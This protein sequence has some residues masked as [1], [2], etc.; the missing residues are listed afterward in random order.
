[1]TSLRSL[2]AINMDLVLKI[3]PYV[4]IAI[5]VLC[6]IVGM[7]KGFR[8]VK[9]S[10]LLWLLAGGGFA[11]IYHFFGE[12]NLL[13]GIIKGSLTSF[14]DIIW[15]F[16]LVVACIG[17][18]LA[19]AAICV[20]IFRFIPEDGAPSKRNAKRGKENPVAE[21]ARLERDR[22]KPAPYFQEAY[23]NAP[24]EKKVGFCG[25]IFGGFLCLLNVLSIVGIIGVFVLVLLLNS[26][27]GSTL[28]PMLSNGLVQKGIDFVS[29]YIFDV[30]TVG[31]IMAVAYKGFNTGLIG[32]TRLLF[33]R[34][35]ML[36]ALIAGFALPFLSFFAN[37]AFVQ[38][39]V[40][41]IIGILPA[42]GMV[43]DVLA[44]L[45]LGAVLAIVGMILMALLNMILRKLTYSVDDTDA[46]RI[47]D[48]VVA[49]I[50]Y[51]VLGL[52]A[53]VAL[54]LVVFLLDHFGVLAI[55]ETL[56]T[57]P[58]FAKECYLVAKS[59]FNLVASKLPFA[60]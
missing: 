16:L 52:V 25:R 11:A 4:G 36:V 54:W 5:L 53:S 32:T 44:R 22:L 28:A 18:A 17:A 46:I 59:L 12:K 3:V 2:L 19:L 40:A 47:I 6:F 20:Y 48:S 60:L 26:Q 21:A 27:L 45:I 13:G 31:I 35:G 58:S 50:V 37:L 9:K 29:K 43:S 14:A 10:G 49:S 55:E 34:L 41:K 42:W 39:I 23:L 33:K 8:K 51:L 7:V 57:I 30:F 24:Q 38:T 56:T 1:M 15:A